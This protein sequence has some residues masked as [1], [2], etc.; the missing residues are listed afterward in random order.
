MQNVFP[1]VL[2]KVSKRGDG[3]RNVYRYPEGYPEWATEGLPTE[4]DAAGP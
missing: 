3:Y 4:R 2:A 1:S